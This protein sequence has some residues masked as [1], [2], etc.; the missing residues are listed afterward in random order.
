MA[1]RDFEMA[2]DRLFAEAPAFGDADLFA[3]RVEDRL[4]R[5]WTF[6]RLLIGGLGM[7]GGLIG[8]GQILSTNL[9]GQLNAFTQHSSEVL[10][11][12]LAT[13]LPEGFRGGVGISAEVIWMSAALA[14]VAVGLAVTRLIREI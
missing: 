12:G 8:G 2:L 1:E 4:D 5:G 11:R 10:N 13:V 14:A 6:R 3:L 7:A 9:F